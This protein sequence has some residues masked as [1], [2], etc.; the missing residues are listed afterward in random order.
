MKKVNRFFLLGA[1]G[2]FILAMPAHAAFDRSLDPVIVL[3]SE[4]GSFLN[5][6]IA[7]V[8]AYAFD[9]AAATW[10]AIPVQVDEFK[11]KSGVPDAKEVDWK[12][13]GLLTGL[14]EI[15]FMAKDMKDKAPDVQTWTNDVASKNNQRYEIVCTDPTTGEKA[16]AYIYYS[17]TLQKSA[18]SYIRYKNDR[19]YGETY[20]MAHHSNVASGLPDSLSIVGN[21]VDI[22]QSWRIRAHIDKLIVNVDLGLGKS[23]FTATN[24]YFSENMNTSIKL[25]YGF[26]TAT[27]QITAFHDEKSLKIQSGAVRVIREHTLG[28]KFETTGFT[29]SSRIPITTYYYPQHV[30]FKPSFSLNIGGDVKELDTDY[31]EFSQGLNSNSSSVKFYGNGFVS[32]TGAQDSLINRNPEN[33]IFKKALTAA[34]WPGK[35]W[36]GLSGQSSSLINNAAFLTICDLNGARIIPDATKPPSLQYYDYVS[37]KYDAGIYGVTGL[38]VYNWKKLTTDDSFEIDARFRSFYFAQNTTRSQMQ[39]LYNKYS[40]P[41][42]LSTAAQIFPDVIPPTRIVD[43]RIIAHTD[44]T[45]TLAWTAPY[46]D[47]DS[48]GPA[49]YYV[50]RYSDIAPTDPVGNDWNWWGP[51]ISVEIAN[52]PAPA[53]PGTTQTFMV[54]GLKEA[55]IYY[56]RMNVADDAKPIPNTSGLSNTASTTTTPVELAAFTAQVMPSRQVLLQ[57][58][59][60]SETNNLGF[61]VQR[62]SGDQQIWQPVKFIPGFGTT[63]EQHQYVF[64]D[65]P[66]TAGQWFYRLKQNDADGVSEF[67]DEISVLLSAPKVFELAQ[68]YPNP[69]NPSTTLTFQIPDNT[70]GRMT[71]MIY[72][73]LGRQVRALVNA[74]AAAG[75]YTLTWDGRDDSGRMTGSGVYIYQL[76]AGN[77]SE[78]KKMIKVQ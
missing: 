8:R 43:L 3:G 2:I 70:A 1:I 12:G 75:Y 74:E 9:A 16:Y 20:G 53:T 26:I 10:N 48:G 47:G 57:W 46:D 38:R 13:A 54:T 27:V 34:D 44:T 73:M 64:T 78:T 42:Q 21:N 56:F 59:T 18:I 51:T 4:C 63:T 41:V 24:F 23:P 76:R 77:L 33:I 32:A 62:R 14:D 30:E 29:D 15:V 17:A 71:L 72:D 31:I 58:T 6:P 35:H 55:T 50:M 28:I 22:L 19:V 11:E 5:K 52:P 36:Y 60:E 49:W 68:N 66:I 7:D 69:F 61:Q 37:D 40:Q 39:Q 67:S 25:T 45:M 65:T